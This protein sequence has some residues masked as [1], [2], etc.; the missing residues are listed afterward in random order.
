[1]LGW[2]PHMIYSDHTNSRFS[3]RTAALKL[4]HSGLGYMRGYIFDG[5]YKAIRWM[6]YS[7]LETR[8]ERPM[9]VLVQGSIKH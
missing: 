9:K 4:I 3:Y 8:H 1:M 2:L 5:I 7:L 6:D